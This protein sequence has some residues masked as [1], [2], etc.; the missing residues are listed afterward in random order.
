MD[1]AVT[2]FLADR[3]HEVAGLL[4]LAHEYLE[5][6]EEDPGDGEQF[7]IAIWLW[8]AADAADMLLQFDWPV[9]WAFSVDT[10]REDA[11]ELRAAAAVYISPT[12]RGGR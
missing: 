1:D 7:R 8:Q 12:P 4:Q 9:T 6:L 10:F 5:I 3:M 11:H 2:S